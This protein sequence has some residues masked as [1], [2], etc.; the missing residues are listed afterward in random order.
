MSSQVGDVE[1]I[2]VLR[3]NALGDFLFSLPALESL[4]AAYGQAEL[5]LLGDAWHQRDL[6]GRP[7]PVDRVIAVP[8]ISGAPVPQDF[9]D[10]AR[11]E[12][13]DIALQMHGG[14][15]HSN[16]FV[17]ALGAR[18]TAGLRA[19]GT[20][21]LD[22]EVP[23]VYFQPE[24]FR[25]L[26]VAELV[27]A[28]AVTYRPRFQVTGED[29]RLAEE[30]AGVPDRRPRVALHPGASD[31]RRRWPAERFA[32]IADALPE[33]EILITG[34][35]A[36]AEL[37]KQVAAMTR[38]RVRTL[39]GA[40]S[41]GGLAGLYSGCHLVIS[42]DTGPLHLAVAIGT[43]T[44]GLYWIGNM[45]NGAPMDRTRHRQ[46][47]SWTLRCPECGQECLS[48]LYPNRFEGSRCEHDVCFVDDIQVAEV[49]EAAT[50]L[51]RAGA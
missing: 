41:L 4:K 36:E 6:S 43:A 48:D 21:A 49:L 19:P 7:G 39:A 50:A 29:L 24:V 22:R 33:A 8:P 23:Y 42:N 35:P 37:V 3:A 15:Q 27:G 46:V 34:G 28:P 14:G 11:A 32:A 26:E 31:S 12:R 40:L 51:T 16:S 45:I 44:V 18:V 25:Y 5:V 13:F 38:R 1:K 9:L 47:I 30:V 2:A 20:P 17:R 10:R